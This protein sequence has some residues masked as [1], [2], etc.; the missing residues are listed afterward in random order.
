MART[1]GGDNL[2]FSS[3]LGGA[4]G[5]GVNLSSDS[6]DEYYDNE[7]FQS[8]GSIPSFHLSNHTNGT[9]N[10]NSSGIWL[11][12]CSHLNQNSILTRQADFQYGIAYSKFPTISQDNRLHNPSGLYP[13]DNLH[14]F[15][16][17][18][19]D[20]LQSNDEKQGGSTQSTDH[21]VKLKQ[22][23]DHP[24]LYFDETHPLFPSNF[25]VNSFQ[26]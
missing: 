8:V 13:V 9:S 26:P 11:N 10:E 20:N 6:W 12:E 25:P 18:A 17:I 24:Y 21:S 5:G 4:N 22:V 23:P 1:R 3:S 7:E 15:S 14:S 16:R 2:S 19:N